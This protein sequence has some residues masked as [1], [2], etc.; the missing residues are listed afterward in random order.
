MIQNLVK[1]FGGL[2]DHDLVTKVVCF[3]ANGVAT[4]QC[5]KIGVATQLGR[6]SSPFCIHVHWVAHMTN[7][8]ALTL[9]DLFVIVK[10]ETL[11]VGVY[12]YFNHSPKR[13]LERFEVMVK[14]MET[15]RFKI[16]CNI[17]TKW[18]Y[19]VVPS[20]VVLEEF[21]TLLVKMVED[22]VTNE[23]VVIN[24]ELLCDI[25][26]VLGFTYLLP[27]LEAL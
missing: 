7:L 21:K 5:I 13:N 9:S 12:K 11:L 3:S 4:F 27:M 6:K 19:M 24:Y 16:L 17:K 2:F 15:K 14:A 20:K 23:Y 8:I 10:T 22:V 26:I 25:E 18:I 1:G